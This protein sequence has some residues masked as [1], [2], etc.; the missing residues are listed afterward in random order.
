MNPDK[1][2]TEG[3]QAE[4]AQKIIGMKESDKVTNKTPLR[5]FHKDKQGAVWIPDEV[6]DHV[7][8]GYTYPEIQPWREEFKTNGVL[9]RAKYVDSIKKVINDKYGK[10]RGQA[11]EILEEAQQNR[12]QPSVSG[13]GGRA[14]AIAVATATQTGSPAIAIAR[15]FSGGGGDEAALQDAGPV[16]EGMKVVLGGNAI[17]SN[18]FAISLRFSRFAF[19][20]HPFSVHV[21]LA[22]ADSSQPRDHA[23]DYVGNVYNFS[24]PAVVNG[25]EV[26]SNCTTLQ[27]QNVKMSAYLPINVVLNRLRNDGT[28]AS[29]EKNDV[30]KLLERL[31]WRV[32]KVRRPSP[33]L[34]PVPLR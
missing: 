23:R 30:S 32:I 2:F 17:E 8:L 27:G 20:G 31:Y 18:D 26:C 28:L 29:F 25:Q 24:S 16:P 21:Y 7:R 14:V 22:P 11:I 4:F 3:G 15:A 1:W 33:H 9:D 34:W 10:V 12:P 6:R 5:P 13:S 19:K